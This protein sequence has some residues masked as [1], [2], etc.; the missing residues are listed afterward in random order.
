MTM[1]KFLTACIV[2]VLLEFHPFAVQAQ[3]IFIEIE[4]G[5]T[6]G[7]FSKTA[8]KQRAILNLPAQPTE[9]ALL[10]F[11][12]WP[13]IARVEMKD[14]VP[15]FYP[16]RG[17][18]ARNRQLFNDAG[19]ATVIVDCPT[20]QWG[21]P[22]PNPS[23]CDDDYRSSIKHATDV[24]LVMD[25][26]RKSHGLTQFYAIG[27]SYGVISSMWLA[28]NL[29]PTL[30]GSIHAAAQSVPG[31]GRFTNYA[32]TA[33]GFDWSSI[34][35]S[36]LHVHHELEACPYTPY[37]TAKRYAAGNLV[38][39]RGGRGEGDHCGGGHY[40]GFLGRDKEF[41]SAVATW[42]KSRKVEAFVG[43]P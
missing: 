7:V 29:G 14:G 32:S 6:E 37:Q 22:G 10:L 19:I 15:D 21:A 17:P 18:L 42:I 1:K 13:G 4:T 8:V 20:D 41:V 34:K 25:S 2:A 43:E 39:V 5:R 30:S 36:V 28:R 35:S 31:G 3:N 23:S 33:R 16:K 24:T 12:G 27:H 11:V 26:L 9:T 40:H 38:T